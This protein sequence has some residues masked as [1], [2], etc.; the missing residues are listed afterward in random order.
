[1]VDIDD[2]LVFRLEKYGIVGMFDQGLIQDV[3]FS[4]CLTV[5]KTLG[6]VDDTDQCRR[7]VLPRNLRRVDFHPP[8][9]A[10]LGLE[11]EHIGIEPVGVVFIPGAPV[12]HP[13]PIFVME[14][15]NKRA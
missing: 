2:F 6:A 13:V 9:S 1:M 10:G 5:S 14:K 8:G 4:E 3:A 12:G 15:T 11:T 7:G